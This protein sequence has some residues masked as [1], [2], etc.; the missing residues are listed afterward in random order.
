MA[1]DWITIWQSELAGLATDRELQEAWVRLVDFWARSAEATL[2]LL[3]QP[4]AAPQADGADR[5]AGAA[6][7][8]GAPP[9]M[10]APDA[11]D[12]ALQRLAERVAELERQFGA[13]PAGAPA[14][15]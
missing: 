15:P 8:P 3:P 9:A 7:P 1:A 6:A 14:L 12:A 5:R 10:A 13:R 4:A 2:R 11:R